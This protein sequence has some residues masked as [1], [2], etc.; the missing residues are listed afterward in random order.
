MDVGQPAHGPEDEADGA[1]R[2]FEALRGGLD[3]LRQRPMP[4]LLD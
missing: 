4:T 3:E 1:E 2:A